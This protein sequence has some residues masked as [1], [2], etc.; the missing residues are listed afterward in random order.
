MRKTGVSHR[1]KNLHPQEAGEFL[2]AIYEHA[3]VGVEQ[4]APDGRLLMVNE[5]LCR[6]LGYSRTELLSKTFDEIIHPDDRAREAA[7]LKKMLAGKYKCYDLEK[8]YLHRDGSSVWTAVTSS[9]VRDRARST[10]YCMSIVRDITQRKLANVQFRLAVE[11][12]PVAMVMAGEDGNIILVNSHAEKLFGYRSEELLQ[13][14]VEILIPAFVREAHLGLRRDYFLDPRERPVG[15]GRDLYALRKDGTQFPVEIG[16]HP[17]EDENGRWVLASI[18]DISGRKRAEEALRKSEEMFSKAFQQSPMSLTITSMKDH[19]YIDINETFERIS[20]WRRE[21][22]IG[23]TPLDIG[24]YVD[25]AERLGLVNRALTEGGFRNQEVRFR[26][27]DGSIR[28]ALMS[29]ELIELGGELS[30]LNVVDD[31]TEHKRVQEALKKSE[32]KFAKA[33]RESPMALTLTSAR[34]HRY[35]DVNETFEHVAGYSR[36]EALGRTALDLGIWV[37]PSQRLKFVRRL[38]AEGSIRNLEVAFRTKDG[39]TRVGLGSAELIEIDG[40]QFV[41]SSVMDITERKRAERALRESEERFRTVFRSAPVGM[42]MISPEGRFLAANEAFCKFVGYSETELLSRDILPVAP[43]GDQAL[44]LE[45]LIPAINS[46][47]GPQ[48]VERR[49]LDKNGKLK[50]GEESV[51]LIRDSDGKPQYFVSQVVDITERKRAEEALRKSEERYRHLVESS[52]DW[53][54]E[55]D[56]EGVY[57]YAG[58]QCRKILGYEPA[59]IVGRTPFDLMPPEE[60]RRVA[61]AFHAIAAE[62]KAFLRLENINLHKDGHLVVLETNGVPVIDEGGFRG[63]RG[64]DRD[65]T[66]RKR[67]EQALRESEERFRFVANAAPVMIWMS[68][69]HRLCT[70]F[71]E[72][73]LAFT[74]RPLEAELGNGWAEGVHPEDLPKCLE[75]YTQSFDRRVPF[76]MEYR[77]RRHDGEYRWIHDTGV[78]RVSPDGSF[79]GYIGSCVDITDRKRAEEALRGVSGKLIEAQEKE[80]KRIARE[81]HDDINQRLA[82]L[83]IDLQQLKDTPGISANQLRKRTEELFKRTTEISTDIQLLSHDLHSSSLEYLGLVSGMRGYCAEFAKH[84]KVEVDFVHSNVP[85]S[86]APDVALGLFRVLQE[87]LSNAMKHSG[88]QKFEARLLGVPGGIQLTVRDSG[89]GLCLET[90]ISGQGLGLISMRERVNL[91][92]GTISISSKPRFGTEITVLIPLSAE[93]GPSQHASA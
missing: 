56:A 19:R 80:R 6:M 38:L 41:L 82:I 77:L 22:V 84:H 50:W 18:I 52:N 58:P 87:A 59:E 79:A 29:G 46:E 76:K 10:I 34:D 44:S 75:T 17:V 55:V 62:R 81:L 48:R 90:A 89:E 64:M 14:P 31:I 32:E 23:R 61:A 47:S 24:L 33:F 85:T 28:V 15:Q 13:Q 20:G 8:R 71:N 53:V 45:A 74:G 7:L 69:P 92:G 66:E 86:L 83:A 63:Y 2:R 30:L 42:V 21:E 27:R 35:V 1:G 16:L 36:E 54:W 37:D 3:A 67:A 12:A 78:P 4:V 73:W 5:A 57:T 9:L 49:F 91:L 40:E 51:S 39:D 25:P 72:P 65:I 43:A 88:V 26:M 68:D 11:S 93:T 70:Y 60:A